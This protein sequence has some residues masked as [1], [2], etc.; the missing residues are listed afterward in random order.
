MRKTESWPRVH[1]GAVSAENQAK[2]DQ[3]YL[4]A[5]G[6]MRGTGAKKS[7]CGKSHSQI[8]RYCSSYM[9]GRR[10]PYSWGIQPMTEGGQFIRIFHLKSIHVFYKAMSAACRC[11]SHIWWR[12]MIWVQMKCSEK[13]SPEV[14]TES[15]ERKAKRE[16]HSFLGTVNW[17]YIKWHRY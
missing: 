15:P 16:C 11:V 9:V 5:S 17:K 10:R 8:E 3:L 2:D 13:M 1:F 14:Q 12:N 4:S 7:E 6:M